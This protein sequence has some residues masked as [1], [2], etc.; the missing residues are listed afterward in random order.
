MRIDPSALAHSVGHL[1]DPDVE[2]GLA[3]VLQQVVTAA[4]VLFGA[5]GTG[6]MLA[7]A[8]GALR[9]ASASD[10]RAQLAEEAQ[11]RLAQGPSL[12]AF[13]KRSPTAIRDASQETR[14]GE[15]GRALVVEGI[16]ATLSVPVELDGGPV[17]TLDIF[18]ASRRDWDVSEIGAVQTYAGIVASLL[19]AAAAAHVKGRLA[20]QLQTALEHRTLVE[21]AK[22]MLMERHGIDAA[23]AFERLRATARSSERR[24]AD[25]ARDVLDGRPL[26]PAAG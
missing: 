25:V 20:D 4:K 13:V 17:G 11:E 23:S 18:A 9:W 22:G 24:V 3:R 15:L 1:Y 16:R 8:D 19:G 26:P 14:W 5:D 10:Q 6:L 2:H 12:E 7:G 21:Q